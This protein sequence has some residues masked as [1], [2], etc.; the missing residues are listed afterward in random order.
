[1]NDPQDITCREIT[2]Q[3]I[4]GVIACLARNFTRHGPRFW[5]RAVNA[6]INYSQTQDSPRWGTVLELDHKIVGV[7]LTIYHITDNKIFCNLS[8]WC[9]DSEYRNYATILTSFTCRDK[10]V[11]Y[12]NLSAAPH[13]FKSIEQLKFKRYAEGQM[14]LIPLLCQTTTA[15]V[16]E[17]N[18]NTVESKLLTDADLQLLIDHKKLGLV[19]LIGIIDNRYVPIILKWMPLWKYIVP[20]AQLIYCQ[21]QNDIEIFAKALGYYCLRRGRL[22]LIINSNSVISCVFGKFRLNQKPLYFRGP[23]EPNPQ[24]LSY[25]EL[26][27]LK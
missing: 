9:V 23:N 8:S 17:F 14:T 11:T 7:L 22:G 1:M 27:L 16:V 18:P 15:K 21:N 24:D 13:T 6:V 25:S 3:D 26:V 19:T 4:P 20:T 5:A 2:Q 10:T 12:T